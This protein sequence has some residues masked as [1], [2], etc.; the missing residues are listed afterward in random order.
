MKNDRKVTRR[1]FIKDGLRYVL[2]GSLVLLPV[3][4]LRKKEPVICPDTNDIPV[5]RT[6]KQCAES[7][8]CTVS[9]VK[10]YEN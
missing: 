1:A 8:S 2:L 9:L 5:S 6:C 3:L 4:R 10:R 7:Q